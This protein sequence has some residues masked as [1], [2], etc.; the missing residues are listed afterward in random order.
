M[1][2]RMLKPILVAA[3]A[4]LSACATHDHTRA[5]LPIDQVEAVY[6]PLI[7][8]AN[9][10]TLDQHGTGERIGLFED[11]QGTVW[12][13]PL[14]VEKG[15]VLACASSELRDAS[16]TDTVTTGSTLIGS[17]NVPTG[18]RGGTGD[19]ELLLRD[20]R[21]GIHVQLVH[22]AEPPGGPLC[23]APDSPGP[24]QPLRYYRVAPA[25]HGNEQ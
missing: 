2:R 18:W 11:A 23:W 21:G 6:G 3:A 24:A 20:A 13:L 22:G 8:A 12:G 4:G 17:T 15:S 16:V 5:F 9:H 19:L 1:L 10:P 7:A 25:A 14:L